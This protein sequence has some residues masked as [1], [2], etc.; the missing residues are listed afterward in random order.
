MKNGKLQVAII[1]TGG[2]AE[3]V[4]LPGYLALAQ[5][6]DVAA[7]C[8]TRP[9]ALA[10]FATRFG[11][12]HTFTDYQQLL[13]SDLGLDA[14]SICTPPSTHLPIA[15]A[16]LAAGLHVMLEKPV[17]RTAAEARGIVDAARRSGR[18]LMIG[19]QYRFSW[20]TQ[21][22]KRIIVSGELGEI[23]YTRALAI[24][25]RGIPG[26]GVFTS[27]EL[28][29]GGPLMDLGVHV[30]DQA[31]YLL[32]APRAVSVFGNVFQKLG[33]RPGPNSFG[34]WDPTH[35][36]TEDFASGQVRFADGSLLLLETSWALNTTR[37]GFNVQ[38]MGTR[39]GAECD[40]LSVNHELAG[41]LMD[42]TPVLPDNPSDGQREKI[43]HFVRCIL[44][45][46]PPLVT[47]DEI[48]LVASILDGIYRSA[49]T[50]HS[51]A[52]DSPAS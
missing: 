33:T 36:E 16:A 52:L 29:G 3:S 41:L 21:A 19:F 38:V 18:K 9:A 2:I 27:K 35:F 37:E 30:L 31:I 25:R 1:G 10:A 7:A 14:V 23:Y 5:E 43:A 26:W 39:G 15:T 46:T 20:H 17:A 4:H 11:I 40:P 51:V 42:L 48:L 28:S 22:L 6:V 44:D 13:E 24:R 12:P 8:D 49:E 32:G 34:P 50:G 47:F 45:D